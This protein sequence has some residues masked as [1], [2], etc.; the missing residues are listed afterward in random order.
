MKHFKLPLILLILTSVAAC[1]T[2]KALTEIISPGTP[3][4]ITDNKTPGLQDY[5]ESILVLGLHRSFLVHL[6]YS[7]HKSRSWPLVIQLHG[8]GGEGKQMNALTGFYNLA[9]QHGFLVISP[10]AIE[11]NWNDGRG[12][13]NVRSHTENIDDVAF[14]S[15]L[16]DRAV[17]ELNADP[18]RVYVTGI[19]NGAMMSHRLACELSGKIAAIAPVAGNFPYQM[20]SVLSPSRPVPVLIIN[21]T[22]DP[23]VPYNGGDVT[24]GL[25]S[26]GKVLSVDETIKFWLKNNACQPEPVVKNLPDTVN[27]STTVTVYYYPGCHDAS[28]VT[29]YEIKGGGHT[30]PGGLQYLREALIGKT[31]LDF[32]ASEVIW[33]FFIQ[34]P[35]K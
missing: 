6:P 24:F 8:G 15:A 26:R 13:L 34:H 22:D 4:A 29:L 1:T 31:C 27:D 9:D 19:S 16:I 23:L 21:G 12:G 32:S 2:N 11:K 28:D 17:T 7:Y 20:A 14:I 5:R 10:D 18:N 33:D 35:M 25:K 30:W 3:D